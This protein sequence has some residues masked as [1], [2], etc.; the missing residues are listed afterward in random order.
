MINS[1]NIPD[2]VIIGSAKS[3]T[4]TL[5][6][7]LAAHPKIALGVKKEPEFFSNEKNFSKGIAFY[8]EN[9]FEASE[10]Q[11]CL[12]ASTSYT[13][14]PQY[15]DV[16]EKLYSASPDAKMIYLMR[17]P[18]DRAYSHFIHRYTKELFPN[19]AFNGTF[20]QHVEN[21]QM[22]IDSSNYKLQIEEYL[23]YFPKESMFF[24]FTEEMASDKQGVL[25]KLCKF[26]LIE[27]KDEYFNEDKIK[28]E[29]TEFLESRIRIGITDRM[30][31]NPFYTVLK[32]ITPVF[33]R[34][35]VYNKMR[36]SSSGIG[37]SNDFT[38]PKL[39]EKERQLLLDKFESSSMW[40]EKLTNKKLLHWYK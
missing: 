20:S 5:A 37:V 39:T 26:L 23:K 12:D 8:R 35:I 16:A 14:L 30:K 21:D 13:R 18:V 4:T 17:H 10:G 29:T 2:I 11:L 24:L 3:G 32:Y 38:A 22:C 27:Y 28:N 34:E 31:K 6:E 1:K 33:L 7:L 15:P 40:I 19:E 9:F 36:Y 25:K